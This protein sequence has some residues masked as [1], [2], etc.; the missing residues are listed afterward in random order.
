MHS[1]GNYSI[2][3]NNRTDVGEFHLRFPTFFQILETKYKIKDHTALELAG[4]LG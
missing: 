2:T 4:I 3:G 1:Y